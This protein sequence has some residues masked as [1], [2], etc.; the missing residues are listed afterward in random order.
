MFDGQL[1]KI[2]INYRDN[3]FVYIVNRYE[4]EYF[5]LVDIIDI[6][7]INVKLGKLLCRRKL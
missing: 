1:E 5:V 6:C 3:Y 4:I 7:V 2:F